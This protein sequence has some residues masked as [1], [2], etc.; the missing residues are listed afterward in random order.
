MSVQKVY[1]TREHSEAVQRGLVAHAKQL[2]VGDPLD[3]NTEVGPLIRQDEVDRVDEWVNEVIEMGAECLIG[4]EPLGSQ[5]YAPTV[6][7][8]P[9]DEAKVSCEEIF[10]PVVC[11]YEYDEVDQAIADANRLNVAFQAAVFA[12]DIDRAHYIADRLAA[13]AVMINE[14]TAYRYDGMPF[15]GLRHSGLGMGGIG[16]SIDDMQ[17]EKLKVVTTPVSI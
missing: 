3:P 4:G 14:H 1:V 5:L 11:V 13:A 9:P 6:L 8:N 7:L 15:G 2:Q 16:H 10:G 12:Q 17:I